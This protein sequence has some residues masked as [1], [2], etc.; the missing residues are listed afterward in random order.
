MVMLQ[1]IEVTVVEFPRHGRGHETNEKGILKKSSQLADTDQTFFP[2]WYVLGFLIN[3][4]AIQRISM[5]GS[6]KRR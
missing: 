4:T 5:E 6:I 1:K 2:T 3:V